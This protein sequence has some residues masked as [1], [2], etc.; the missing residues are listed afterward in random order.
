MLPRI[1]KAFPSLS[2]LS[3]SCL[4]LDVSLPI[5]KVG[6]SLCE[7][8]WQRLLWNRLIKLFA[9]RSNLCS[10]VHCLLKEPRFS[11]SIP[12]SL[13]VFTY[14]RTWFRKSLLE[15]LDGRKSRF[16]SLY[17]RTQSSL[18]FK[19]YFMKNTPFPVLSRIRGTFHF[20]VSFC[21]FLV[22]CTLNSHLFRF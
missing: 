5:D 14:E 9:T 7:H 10:A 18:K 4:F 16:P 15:I 21:G 8:F 20:R 19:S 11:Q 22:F 1:L 6:W 2:I 13:K 12:R 3:H 17:L